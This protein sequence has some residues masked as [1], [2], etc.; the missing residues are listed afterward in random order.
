MNRIDLTLD[1][2]ANNKFLTMYSTLIRRFAASTEFSTSEVVSLLI[3]FYKYA[4]NNRSRM[5]STSQ[6][7]N[8]FLVSF[9]IFDV[10]IIDRIS[11]NI[12]QDGRSVSPE[13][14]MRLFCVFFTGNLQERIKFAFEVYTSGGTVVLNREVVGVAIEKFFTGD[15]EDEV[16]E[17]QADMCEFIFGKFDTDKDG[18]I[19]FD[20]YAE[21]VHH[22]PG[23]LEFL[24]KI[25]PDDKDRSLVAYCHNIESMFPPEIEY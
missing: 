15:D 21:I 9:G 18:V 13:A 23:L 10:T 12:T 7:Y 5:M 20:E 11:M 8:L 2:M 16:N 1:D 19:A 3:V 14:W 6:L 17:L 4:L 25:F 22:Q 24:G